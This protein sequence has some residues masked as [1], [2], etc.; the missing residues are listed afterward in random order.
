MICPKC[1]RD[2]EYYD[3]VWH[4]KRIQWWRCFD[5]RYEEDVKNE[6]SET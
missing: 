4:G 1:Q 6:R 3:E 5:C 2:M